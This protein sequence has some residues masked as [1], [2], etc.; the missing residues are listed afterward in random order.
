MAN[1][2]ETDWD[3][4]SP[5]LNQARRAGAA[6]ILSLRQGTRL[7]LSREHDTL[8]AAGAGGTHKQGSAKLYR[9][10]A[11]P[12]LRPDGT[13]PL[14]S[15]DAGRLWLDTDTKT[16]YVWSGSAWEEIE[17]TGLV[18]TT[19]A[20]NAS[21]IA[22]AGGWTNS[23]GAPVLVHYTASHSGT[24]PNIYLELDPLASGSWSQIAAG[25]LVSSFRFIW[26]SVIVPNGG[27][28]R[29]TPTT[30]TGVETFGQK[31]ALPA[32]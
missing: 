5:A 17:S 18:V 2:V 11:A 13:T 4:S 30:V 20:P 10:A 21:Q 31:L 12:T 16:I 32:F 24:S 23:S 28:L 27:K 1:T 29:V 26:A 9:Q 19:V 7:R 6:E 25:N 8:A 14:D 15:N 3:E 22:S